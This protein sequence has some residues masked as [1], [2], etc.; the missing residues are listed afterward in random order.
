MSWRSE[1][2]HR[3][4]SSNISDWVDR[5]NHRFS[6]Q[7]NRACEKRQWSSRA[8]WT[9]SSSSNDTMNE[10]G[11]CEAI[12]SLSLLCL[13][14]LFSSPVV[15]GQTMSHLWIPLVDGQKCC[16]F[17][18]SS[19]H[20][21]DRSWCWFRKISNL[22]VYR[23][24]HEICR[25]VRVRIVSLSLLFARSSTIH[26]NQRQAFSLP[27]SCSWLKKTGFLFFSLFHRRAVASKR[28]EDDDAFSIS[29][30]FLECVYSRRTI[31]AGS[32]LARAGIS[33]ERYLRCRYECRR[34]LGLFLVGSRSR[35]WEFVGRLCVAL[36]Y[37]LCPVFIAGWPSHRPIESI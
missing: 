33:K 26:S 29:V 25:R 12:S 5:R 31:D 28:A 34:E 37:F 15:V 3:E 18:S 22:H 7:V 13:C 36:E 21:I 19:R 10:T 30:L 35:C 2:K 6:P 20:F 24:E 4:R 11:Q 17:T 8:T 32:S 27:R 23:S 9:R 1:R 14:F 16:S